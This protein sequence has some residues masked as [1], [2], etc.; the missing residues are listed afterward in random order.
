M[1]LFGCK[2][3]QE[4]LIQEEQ[5]PEKYIHKVEDGGVS[6]P[7]ASPPQLLDVPVIDLALLAASSITADEY[8]KLRSALDT[9][10][11]FQVINHGMSPEFLDEVR[12]ITKQ[13]FALPVEDKKKYLRQGNDVQGYGNDVV[14]TEQQKLDWTDRLY[15]TVFPQDNRK[16]EVWPENPESFR[17]TLDE[18]ATEL[19][20]VT[21]TVLKAMTRSLGLEDNCFSDLYGNMDIRFNL[22]PPCPRPDLVLGFKSHSDSS[23]ITHVLQD[24]EVE[25]LQFLKGDEWFRAPIVPD[26]LLIIVG[27]Q[28]EI[29]SNGAFKGAVHQVVIHPDKERISVAAF[30][31][32]E[33]Y[34]I[35]PFERLVD[36]SRPRLYRKMENY[37]DIFMENYQKGRRTIEEAK[38]YV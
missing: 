37:G 9:L 31:Y 26:A 16:L 10:G 29:L 25:G 15:L 35:E 5:V 30:C 21:K 18:F 22:Y 6:V 20:V 17:R 28:V 24:K 32:G 11:C 4:V 1:E 3:V 12:E 19:N 36:E 2:T 27:D 38:I 8:E 7:D 14:Y 33:S 23:L 34:K 13:F